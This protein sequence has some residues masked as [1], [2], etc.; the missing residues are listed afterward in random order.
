MRD[1]TTVASQKTDAYGWVINEDESVCIIKKEDNY[2]LC[3]AV[4]A[5][6]LLR[7]CWAACYHRL[8]WRCVIHGWAAHVIR[9]P[10]GPRGGNG[11]ADKCAS[12][13]CASCSQ[14]CVKYDRSRWCIIFIHKYIFMYRLKMY[15]NVKK[16]N[17]SHSFCNRLHITLHSI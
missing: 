7:G 11:N 5:N 3:S 16:N 1:V 10:F 17:N 4:L 6:S 12:M 13:Q 8:P 2:S 14:L 15:G 9:Y